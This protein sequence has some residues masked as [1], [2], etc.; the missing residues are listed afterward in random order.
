MNE[1][2]FTP[3]DL[4]LDPVS[5]E[6]E[7]KPESSGGFT[8][9]P[10]FTEQ[11][12][13]KTEPVSQTIQALQPTS[14]AETINDL[15][16]DNN[17]AVV[18]NYMKQ[19]F[20]MTEDTHGR[21]EVIDSFVNH[22]RKFNFGQSVTTGTELA[23]LNK[24]EEANK[25]AAGQAYQLFD[26]MKGA[27]SEEYSF[28][29]KADAVGDYARALVVDPVNVLSLGFGKLITG[30][31]TK[32]AATLAKDAVIKQ[33]KQE[34]GKKVLKNAA[35]KTVQAQAQQIERRIIGKIIKGEKVRG[36]AKGAFEE[37]V[38]KATKKEILAV[39]AFDSASAV[40]IDAVYQKAL[41]QGGVQ[42]DY[43]V[44]Q[45]AVT[46][47]GGVFGGSL[48]YGLSLLNKAPHTE[49]SLP[50]AMSFFD[51]AAV[52]EANAKKLASTTTLKSNKA[53]LKNIN[54][55]ALQKSL[56]KSA[57]ASERWAKKVLKGDAIRRQN[58]INVEPRTDVWLAAFLH[59][60]KDGKFKGIKTIL[61]D[62]NIELV[63]EGDKFANFTD[64]LTENIK[65]LPKDA[66][67]EVAKLYKNTMANVP[68]F[69]TTLN[70]GLNV[71]SSKASAWGRE[72][73][74]LSK[75]SQD[76]KL[77]SRFA[78]DKTPSQKLNTVVNTTLDPT[79]KT[80]RDKVADG[81]SGM[82]QN[83]IRMLITHPGTTALNVVGWANATS[84]QSV[85]D[86]LRGALYGGRSLAEMAIGRNTNATE[87]A[88][89]SKLMF[90]LQKQKAMNLVNP[91]ATQQSALDFLASNPKA[92]KELFRYMAG[93]IEL[94]DVY[95]Q[96]GIQIGDI[97]KPGVGEK[98]MN[99]A[100]TMYGVK[101]QDM[102]TK[103]QEFMYALDK[104][105]RIKYGKTYSEFLEDPDL[106]KTMK[107][108][109]YAEIQTIAVEDALRNVYAKSY[110]KNPKG[111][112]SFGAKVIEDMRKYPVVGAMI[113]FGQF[114]NN[115]L[116]HMFDH[117]GVSLA[118]KYAVG[119]TR[120]PLEL[121]TKSAIGLSLMGV[122]AAREYDNM[123]EGLA[124]F[125][126]RRDDGSIR[127]R[128]YD[129]PFSFY[130]GMGR[131]GAHFYRD[132]EVPPDLVKEL[133]TLFGPGQLTRQLGDSA[134]ISFD[135]LVDAASQEDGAVKDALSKL[136]QDTA[137][138]YLSGYSRPFDPVNTAI[139]LGR[140]EDFVA[141]DRNQGSKWLNNST[142]YV[143]QIYTALSGAELAPEKFNAL[144][145]ARGTA[146]I[147]R[148]FGYRENPGQ[149]HIQ[150]MFNQ[151]GKPQWRTEIKSFIPETQNHINKIVFQF[152]EQQAEYALATPAWKNGTNK[153]RKA[154]LS[155]VLKK[156]KKQTTDILQLSL[157]P[158]DSR[159]NKLYKI[160]KKGSGVTKEDVDKA[161]TK[162]DIDVDITELDENQ[163]DFLMYYLEAQKDEVK[164]LKMLGT[165]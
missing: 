94:D 106:Y 23:Y 1:F 18:G 66:K 3:V 38:K 89:K 120:D 132:G 154:L 59:G 101:A 98:V 67:K 28:A 46:G 73:Q 13:T 56:N 81:A 79:P 84:M 27:F 41:Q 92:Q 128:M 82:Q 151:I 4:G 75:L 26:N 53:T 152:L 135:L 58:G 147:G 86:I 5:V 127:N 136:V 49:E 71:L 95:K 162:L 113:P 36:V 32:V 48:A 129:F 100:Q 143:D 144:T 114:F 47:I 90:T 149:T 33:V 141:V 45:G 124:W 107:G 51:N 80:I 24:A 102:Y 30:G 164:K 63:N 35:S 155:E 54:A 140:G 118:H 6:E 85:T 83:L 11:R 133:V 108:D 109:T 55:K 77:A 29:Q 70:K 9:T 115:T 157:A 145:D 60:S 87:F 103:T 134:K 43:N 160:S 10:V 163:L 7:E 153:Q 130:K 156:A 96:L 88:N 21:Q 15:M 110:G 74:T 99:F 116:G 22:M 104:Q 161:L 61:E 69:N 20:G 62:F 121:L 122:T 123:E 19:R 72:G 42:T 91:F 34:L 119:T 44:V 112:L 146:P 139:A 137:S 159:T 40:T 105:V 31:A 68:E 78:P 126:E 148:I 8:F 64:F 14:S 37:G 117:T 17:Y 165:R 2:T 52:A 142:R 12:E 39:T 131:M 138:M 25:L 158:E 57:T 16:Q 76:L 150:K 111:L 125:E 50:L 93:G 65:I 97:G